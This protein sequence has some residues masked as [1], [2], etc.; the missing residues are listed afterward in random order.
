MA[1]LDWQDKWRD[2]WFPILYCVLFNN[3]VNL[4]KVK[5]LQNLYLRIS[6]GGLQYPPIWCNLI[7]CP[8]LAFDFFH[9]IRRSIYFHIALV[10]KLIDLYYLFIMKQVPKQGSCGVNNIM[11]S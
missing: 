10:S 1:I 7:S 6:E 3:S 8:S 5:T 9:F 11:C 4:K 2:S